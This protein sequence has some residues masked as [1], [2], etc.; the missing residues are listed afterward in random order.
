MGRGVLKHLEGSARLNRHHP[1]QLEPLPPYESLGQNVASFIKTDLLA[2]I[3]NSGDYNREF[4]LFT[5]YFLRL[6]LFV[7]IFFIF[8][9]TLF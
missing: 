9:F 8:F 4:K 5:I 2:K 3:L 6:T 1:A 7:L